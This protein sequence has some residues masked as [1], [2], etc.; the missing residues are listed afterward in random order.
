MYIFSWIKISLQCKGEIIDI[1]YVSQNVILIFIK[2][3][4]FGLVNYHK[5]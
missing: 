2:F 1:K 4:Q 5:M 3:V